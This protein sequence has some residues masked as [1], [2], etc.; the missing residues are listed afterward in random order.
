MPALRFLP[1]SFLRLAAASALWSVVSEQPA[2]D[3]VLR[4]E[5]RK[6]DDAVLDVLDLARYVFILLLLN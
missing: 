6:A 3:V 5:F 1:P 2:R 4:L